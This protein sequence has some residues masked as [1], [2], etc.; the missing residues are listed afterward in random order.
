MSTPSTWAGSTERA[1]GRTVLILVTILLVVAAAVSIIFVSTDLA[2]GGSHLP[3]SVH[4]DAL[5]VIGWTGGTAVLALVGLL[6]YEVR[7]LRRAVDLMTSRGR[8]PPIVADRPRSGN[9][10]IAGQTPYPT[11]GEL[12]RATGQR[13]LNP[14]VRG[15]SPWRRTAR[16][17]PKRSGC[18]AM[19]EVRGVF[20]AQTA[21]RRNG[22][23][24]ARSSGSGAVAES[25]GSGLGAGVAGA[26]A[27][28]TPE[29]RS[30]E[31]SCAVA[32]RWI[33]ATTCW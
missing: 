30:H 3:P 22:S 13:T 29:S 1:A 5:H 8:T 32:V 7:G 28:R 14:R 12:R 24:L 23:T 11:V 20:A 4:N 21:R 15:S 25:A 33:A 2:L 19:Q 9:R 31:L 16:D 18:L 10:K 17:Q 27:T 6:L 26:G